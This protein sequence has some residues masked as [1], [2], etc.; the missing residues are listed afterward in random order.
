MLSLSIL[1]AV[2]AEHRALVA[3]GLGLAFLAAGSVAAWT[4]RARLGLKP[5]PLDATLTEL[6]KDHDLFKP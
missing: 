3:I 4:A 5:R 6:A 2:A 1:L